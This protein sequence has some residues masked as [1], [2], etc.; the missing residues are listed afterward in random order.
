LISDISGRIVF[1]GYSN[2]FSLNGIDAGTY[3][4]SVKRLSDSVVLGVSRLI[5]Q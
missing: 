4:V 2:V 1:S 3:V 5:V